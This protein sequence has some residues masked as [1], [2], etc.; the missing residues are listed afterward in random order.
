MLK[1]V[2]LG[3]AGAVST[4]ERMNT[5]LLIEADKTR[6]LVD[7]GEGTISRLRAIGLRPTDA[8]NIIITHCHPDHMCQLGGYL[9]QTFCENFLYKKRKKVEI[10]IFC[11]IDEVGRLKRHI[12]SYSIQLTKLRNLSVRVTG[13]GHG[14]ATRIGSIRVEARKADHTVSTIATRYEHKKSSLCYSSDTRPCTS[15]VNLSKSVDLLIHEATFF[16]EEDAKMTGHSTPSQAGSIASKSKAQKLVLVGMMVEAL[17]DLKRVKSEAL[18]TYD[19]PVI[20]PSDFDMIP[21]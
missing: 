12:D 19:G 2:F 20:V 7:C 10:Q 11:P 3:T 1:V 5:S 18:S 15:V 6:I 4:P 17:K 8:R 21:I 9:L 13:L 16:E 14:R